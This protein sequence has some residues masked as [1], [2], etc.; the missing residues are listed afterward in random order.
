MIFISLFT[1]TY[2]VSAKKSTVDPIV[3][4]QG[5][6]NQAY[7]LGYVDAAPLEMAAV[8][9]KVIEAKT[10]Q[11]KRKKK[12]LGKLVQQIKVDLEVVKKRFEVNELYEEL[13]SLQQRNRQ[14]KKI[15]NDLKEQLQ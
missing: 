12:I 15:L 7:K 9:K 8:E 4:V 1:M 11:Q 5:L 2:S 14:S 10:A 6:I 3:V 13:A